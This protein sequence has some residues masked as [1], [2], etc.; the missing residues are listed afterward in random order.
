VKP[1]LL[2]TGRLGFGAL[3][4]ALAL[5]GGCAGPPEAQ[6]AAA[7]PEPAL[8]GALEAGRS[9]RGSLAPAGVD[10]YPAELAAGA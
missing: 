2:R 5:A 8:R 3:A 6:P 7:A 1:A 10:R 4:V 9:Y